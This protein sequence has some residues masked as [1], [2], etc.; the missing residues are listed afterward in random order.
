LTAD[1]A[2]SRTVRNTPLLLAARMSVLEMTTVL[3]LTHLFLSPRAEDCPHL[4]NTATSTMT[5]SRLPS[6]TTMATMTTD[7]CLSV[8][9]SENILDLVT[10]V[11]AAENLVLLELA[12]FEAAL[13]LHL[14]AA[15]LAAAVVRQ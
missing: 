9:V 13:I 8:F 15:P 14:Q 11:D 7:P 10:V 6:P 5:T 2:S 4:A 3:L 12:L 1:H